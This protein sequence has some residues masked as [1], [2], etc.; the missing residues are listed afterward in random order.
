[1]A[2]P[3]VSAELNRVIR[4]LRMSVA[5][6]MRETVSFF[7]KTSSILFVSTDFFFSCSTLFLSTWTKM[8]VLSNYRFS[9][10]DQVE[11][12]KQQH[13]LLVG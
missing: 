2:S 5:S 12:A 10:N 11:Q 8:V 1:M 6:G 3:Q 7:K 13:M 4:W 9:P